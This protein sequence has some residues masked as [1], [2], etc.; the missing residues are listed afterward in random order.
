MP[1]T[2]G[3]EVGDYALISQLDGDGYIQT[4]SC[5]W[6]KKAGRSQGQI[7]QIQNISGTTIEFT[8]SLYYDYKASFEPELSK[9]G[10]TWTENTGLE[11][12]YIYRVNGA[13]MQG[14]AIDMSQ[15]AYSWMMNV[16]VYKGYG[17][18]V[19]LQIA[20]RNVLQGNY[21]HH[22][23]GYTSGAT[24]YGI[25]VRKYATDNLIENNIIFFFNN[26]LFMENAGAGNVISYN[27][28]DGIWLDQSGSE[29]WQAPDFGD[30]CSHNHMDLFEGNMATKTKLDNVHQS[31]VAYW[32]HFR[33]HFDADTGW[34]QEANPPTDDYRNLTAFNA[35]NGR[36]IS[37]VGCVL[38]SPGQYSPNNRYECRGQECDSDYGLDY[39]TYRCRVESLCDETLGTMHRHGNVDFITAQEGLVRWSPDYGGTLPKSYYLTSKPSWWDEQGEG[40]PWPSI[41]P[42]IAGYVIDIPAKDRFEG[43]IYSVVTPTPTPDPT[44]TFADVP[45]D[46]WAHDV[47]EVLY[48]QGFIAG[49]STD[50]L[51]YCPDDIMSRAE[52]AVFVERG[53]HG[54]EFMPVQPTDEIFADVPLWEWFAKWSTALWADGYT[55]GC[56]TDPL[57]YCPL[58][59]H[60]RT[61]GC[62]FFLRMLHGT[63]YEPPDPEGIFSDVSLDGWGAKWIEAAYNA[64][65]I[66]ACE[67]TPEL[68]FCPDDPLDRAMGAYM[69][70]QAKGLEVP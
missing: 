7:V 19:R 25:S 8:P 35:D 15:T 1:S 63:D 51:M 41:G 65:L 39:V 47:I 68:R 6:A 52:S 61:E 30:H 54:A 40:R 67:T 48:Q 24:S 29:G 18:I 43:E 14:S 53:V 64:G 32:L 33:E 49:C 46:H 55:A 4:G 13:N 50:P 45:F 34:G 5:T 20:F 22:A 62:V 36:W 31:T 59:G 9:I 58:Q 10:S 69:M 37:V 38:G 28:M 2:E 3:Y 23:W 66:P 60:T 11:D 12:M 56:G 44:P 16:E 57:M 27:F 70:V 26:A 17:H 42:D 21:I